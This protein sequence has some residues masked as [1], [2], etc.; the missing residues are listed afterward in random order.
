[1]G[2]TTF[3]CPLS[4]LTRFT[5]RRIISR[6]LFQVLLKIVVYYD[7]DGAIGFVS[8]I[9]KEHLDRNWDKLY[10]PQVEAENFETWI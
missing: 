10:A 9:V 5:K 2:K 3:T 8:R 7:R 6:C 1:M 4:K